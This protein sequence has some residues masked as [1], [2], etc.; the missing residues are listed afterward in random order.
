M[1]KRKNSQVRYAFL[2]GVGSVL[3][4]GPA[5]SQGYRG[6]YREPP[7]AR[8]ALYGDW[9]SVGASLQAAI[10]KASCGSKA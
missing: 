2:R 9:N 3:E 4:I 10:E 5:H 6:L 8:D 1:K 7:S